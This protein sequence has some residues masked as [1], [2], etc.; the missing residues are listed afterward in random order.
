MKRSAKTNSRGIPALKVPQWFKEWKKVN[1][2]EKDHR[3]KPDPFFYLFSVNA[4]DLRVL[5]GIQRRSIK[6]GK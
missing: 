6:D 3:R 4:Y 5:S 2:N 1:Y